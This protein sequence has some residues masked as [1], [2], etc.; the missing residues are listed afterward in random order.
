MEAYGDFDEERERKRSASPFPALWPFSASASASVPCMLAGLPPFSG[1]IA[2]FALI[3]GS[4]RHARPRAPATERPPPTGPM[5][6][7][8]ILSGLAAMIAMNRIGIRTFW[9][10][11]RAVR[12]RGSSDR[13]HAGRVLAR[14][15]HLPSLQAGPGCVT[16][17]TADDLLAPLTHSDRVLSAPRA[18]SQ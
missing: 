6:T 4:L 5:S 11:D 14:S 7:L 2:K 3:S 8:L 15:L 16:A 10:S 12:S 18:G 17:A 9:A 13:D 1:F